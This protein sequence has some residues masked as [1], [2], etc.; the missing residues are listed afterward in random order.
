MLILDLTDGDAV[1]VANVSDD[2][3][4]PPRIFYVSKMLDKCFYK[5]KKL[6]PNRKNGSRLHLA[7]ISKKLP[8]TV[9]GQQLKNS[10]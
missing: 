10:L 9:L 7:C 4:T 1:D 2:A 6:N 5:Q 8:W 3:D